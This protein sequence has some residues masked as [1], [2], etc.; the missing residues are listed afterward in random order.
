MLYLGID[1]HRKQLTVNLRDESGE[2]ILKRQVSTRWKQIAEFLTDLST[3]AAAAGG[4]VAIVEV[5]GFNDWLLKMLNSHGLRVLLVQPEQRSRRK[6]DRRDADHLGELLWVNRQRFQAGQKVHGVRV[7]QPPT[8]RD[9][10]DR[11]LTALRR[12][13]TQQRTQTLNQVQHILLKH[14]LQQDCPTKGMH[15]K[16]AQKWLE[17]LELPSI[18]RMTMTLLLDQWRLWDKQLAEVHKQVRQRAGESPTVAIIS[19]LPGAGA[20]ISL[21]LASRIG[22]IER[23]PNP[24]S[25]GNYFGLVPSCRNSGDATKRIGSITKDGSGIARYALGLM[26]IHLLRKD[27]A[28]RQWYLGIKRR[29]GA[30]IAR[31]AVMRRITT[32]LWHMLR[33]RQAY[34]P[35]KKARMAEAVLA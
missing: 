17:T 9:A 10:E 2:V 1:Q 19:S 3:R 5:C 23:F 7:V 28:I 11:Q 33:N 4:C 8:P 26:V 35:D 25:L 14:N 27:A 34:C 18:D 16:R 6:T 24:K 13:L 15:T 20:F 31:V 21:I 29:R 32:L 12:R 22:V 30:K